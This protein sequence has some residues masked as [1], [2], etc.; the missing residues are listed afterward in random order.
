MAIKEDERNAWLK[1]TDQERKEALGM[2]DE[3][4]HFLNTAK[5]ERETVSFLEEHLTANGFIALPSVQKLKAGQKIF[6]K[7]RD[8]IAAAAIIGKKP[9]IDGLNIVASHSDVPRLDLK[10]SPLYEDSGLALFKTHYYGGIKKY[11]WTALPLALHGVVVKKSGE[12]VDVRIGEDDDDPVFT[13]T[14]LLPH[15]AKDQMEKKMSEGI[16]GEGLN[17]LIGS[18]PNTKGDKKE[19]EKDRI[20]AAIKQHLQARYGIDEEDFTSADLQVVPALKAREI[21]FDRSMIGA[22]GQDDR[23]S[24][25]T[26]LKALLDVEKPQRTVMCVFADKEEIGSVGN[27]GLRSYFIEN[28]LSDLMEKAGP[29]DYH[30][31]RKALRASHALSADVNGALDPN[32]GEVFDKMN[33]AKVGEGV[34]VTK[35]TGSRGKYD[36]SEAHAEFVAAIRNLFDENE[37]PW[38]IGELG[39][40]DQGGGGTVAQF[41][42]RYGMDVLDCGVAILGMHSPYEVASVADIYAAYKAYLVFMKHF[43]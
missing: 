16:T 27:T 15:L 19:K 13:I 1:L 40:V 29:V 10:P 4:L 30:H 18:L 2:A 32:Y 35:Y 43:K 8:K 37:V 39:K 5:T 38:Q 34:S 11:Q 36:A 14:D 31:I 25:F 42:A 33:S 7:E 6:I 3:Y 26:S 12:K 22:Y 17:V 21:G 23:I 41:L 9:F 24:V 28:A 20:K